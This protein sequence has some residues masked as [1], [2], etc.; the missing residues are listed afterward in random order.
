MGAGLE[1]KVCV[2]TG[3]DIVVD[4]RPDGLL[5]AAGGDIQA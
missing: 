3:T 2:I 1:S 5:T 4:G